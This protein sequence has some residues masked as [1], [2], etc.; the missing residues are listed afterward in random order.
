M[1]ALAEQRVELHV[2]KEVI[3]P[4]HVPLHGESESVF[5]DLG[6]Y[7]R[8]CGGFLCNHDST[9]ISAEQAGVH[10][11]KELDCFKVLIL[12]I[13]VCDPF[14]VF[15]AVIQIQHGS[16]SVYAQTVDME[17]FDPVKGIGHKE[18]LDFRTAVIINLG[19]PVRML[20]LTRILVL[21]ELCSVETCK[22]CGVFREVSRYPVKDDAD[23][24]LMEIVDHVLE[25]VRSSVAGCRCIIARDLI[26]P[27]SVK[28][29]LG[30]THQLDMSVAHV[31]AVIGCFLSE[32]TIIIE[33]FLA[34][35]G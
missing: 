33:A 23:S 32:L 21:I 11:L 15:L 20:A 31:L 18:V 27:G 5:L 26:S 35:S 16:N 14:A 3:H 1:V 17:E 4:A 19:T 12:T 13:L 9:L 25:V 29:M 7:L 22:T 24:L 30:N 8:P 34:S 28:R 6:C 10:M 2:L